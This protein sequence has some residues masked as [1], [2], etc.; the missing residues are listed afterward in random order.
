MTKFHAAR[1]EFV[2]TNLV[3]ES[4][5]LFTT[6]Q[7]SN[8]KIASN[9]KTASSDETASNNEAANRNKWRAE[10][11][12][13][14]WRTARRKVPAAPPPPPPPPSSAPSSRPPLPG[15]TAPDNC[16]TQKAKG[17]PL[18]PLHYGLKAERRRPP[19]RI[20]RRLSAGP[21]TQKKTGGTPLVTP[22]S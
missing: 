13:P 21:P 19:L 14:R 15:T 12:L 17:L 18:R 3:R 10:I 22:L 11:K 8:H 2:F 9:N 5:R 6:V 1:F 20:R 7:A 4:P 16:L